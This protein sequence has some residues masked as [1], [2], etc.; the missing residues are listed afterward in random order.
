MVV[1]YCDMTGCGEKIL[2]GGGVLSFRNRSGAYDVHLCQGCW[3]KLMTALGPMFGGNKND[4]EK[5]SKVDTPP[6]GVL[7]GS[8]GGEKEETL[9]APSSDGTIPFPSRA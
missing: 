5:P 2:D 1:A 9:T 3:D 8:V 4:V 6:G 7:G